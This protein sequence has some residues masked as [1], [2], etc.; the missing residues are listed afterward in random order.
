VRA[1]AAT[2]LGRLNDTRAVQALLSATQ[3]PQQSVRDAASEALNGMGMAAVMVVVASVMRDAVREQLAATGEAGDAPK[4]VASGIVDSTLPAPEA[5]TG[6]TPPPTAA[7]PPTWAQEVLG[8][9][10]RR[11]GGQQ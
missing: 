9:L 8:R 3:D 6:S 10:L 7:H 5:A 11:T 2:A 1:A 4:Q